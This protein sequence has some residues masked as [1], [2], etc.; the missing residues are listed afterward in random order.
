MQKQIKNPM[1]EFFADLKKNKNKKIFFKRN[2]EL[3]YQIM[4]IN[5]KFLN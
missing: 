1:S 5:F 4:D 3:T 2:K